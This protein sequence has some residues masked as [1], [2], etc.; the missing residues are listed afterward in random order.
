MAFFACALRTESRDDV[1]GMLHL[2]AS[3][4]GDD[5]K[6]HVVQ[7]ERATALRA[8]EMGMLVVV[9]VVAVG[10]KAQLV[11]VVA[12]RPRNLMHQT[13]PHHEAQRAADHALVQRQEAHLQFLLRRGTGESAQMPGK[14]D[15]VGRGAD[16]MLLQE[17]LGRHAMQA[18]RFCRIARTW[19][20]CS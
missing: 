9:L 3:G 1:M 5:G 12:L 11:E 16:A 8:T 14:Q 13:A 19:S 18:G 6:F 20:S 10:G 15:A 2:I 7:A 17:K 4:Q